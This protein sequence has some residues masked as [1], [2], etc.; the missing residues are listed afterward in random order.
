MGGLG[1]IRRT[2]ER[3]LEQ[4]ADIV[5]DLLLLLVEARI[6]GNL[7]QRGRSS[8]EITVTDAETH[9]LIEIALHQQDWQKSAPARNSVDAIFEGFSAP[10]LSRFYGNPCCQK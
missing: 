2:C 10:R 6:A 4:F 3:L 8:G 5:D 7:L 1:S 9:A